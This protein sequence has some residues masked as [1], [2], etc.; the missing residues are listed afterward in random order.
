MTPTLQLLRDACQVV[1]EPLVKSQ[2]KSPLF[3]LTSFGL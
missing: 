1:P 2:G 3:I